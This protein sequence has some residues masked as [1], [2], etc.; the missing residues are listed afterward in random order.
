MVVEEAYLAS[1]SSLL[2]SNLLVV[3]EMLEVYSALWLSW[4]TQHSCSHHEALMN[5]VEAHCLVDQLIVHLD[6]LNLVGQADLVKAVEVHLKT[7]TITDRPLADI[8]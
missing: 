8:S 6:A 5:S 7:K 1:S 4:V 2:A 3:T